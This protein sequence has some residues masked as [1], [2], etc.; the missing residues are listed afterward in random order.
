M[1]IRAGYSFSSLVKQNKKAKI[2]KHIAGEKKLLFYIYDVIVRQKNYKRSSNYYWSPFW[3]LQFEF[4]ES[5]SAI[6]KLPSSLDLLRAS[7]WAWMP[8]PAAAKLLL[9]L[10]RAAPFARAKRA[11]R[12]SLLGPPSH[13]GPSSP[14]S[15]GPDTQHSDRAA[16]TGHNHRP[17]G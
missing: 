7:A 11:W 14:S 1:D 15:Q 4:V 13:F 2:T 16:R 12:S 3:A 10:R 6:R 9:M 17:A 5:K 8:W